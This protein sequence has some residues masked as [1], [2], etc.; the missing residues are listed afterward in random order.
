MLLIPI[1]FLSLFSFVSFLILD[2]L[3]KNSYLGNSIKK[4]YSKFIDLNYFYIVF[5]LTGIVFFILMLFSYLG[6]SLFCFD[7]SS[8][9]MDLFKFT[10]D[11]GINNNT[12]K[13]DGIGIVNINHHNLSVSIPSS[14]LNNLA[15]AA[16]VASGGGLALKVVQQIPG[17]PGVKAAAGVATL[18]GSQALTL[19]V[20]KI[21]NS[22]N[23]NNNDNTKQLINWFDGLSNNNLNFI[24][25]LKDNN[26]MFNDF[27][28]NLLPEINQ[29]ATA[30][31]MFLFIILNIFIV[32]YITSLDYNKYIPKNK[33]GNIFKII[34]S[35]YIILWSNSVKVLLI[36]SWIGLFI[37]V[38]GS[39]IFLYY[40]LNS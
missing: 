33:A 8:F 21:L 23:S 14:S 31:L 38:I 36:V 9:D 2:Y 24:S 34:I 25:N 10:G 12:V 15:A 20:S 3:I 29:L 1:N 40:V 4:K 17:G 39:K 13:S 11:T 32:K 18:L 35:R 6:V 16:S 5:I 37:C 30:E 28:L 22:N 7:N 19:G 26:V 27:P